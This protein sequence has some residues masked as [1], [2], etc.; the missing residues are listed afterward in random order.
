M[1]SLLP[2]IGREAADDLSKLGNKLFER[3]KLQTATPHQ[4]KPGDV[5]HVFDPTEESKSFAEAFLK[6]RVCGEPWGKTGCLH[7]PQL[8]D[9]RAIARKYGFRVFAPRKEPTLLFQQADNEE[10]AVQQVAAAYIIIL[11]PVEL[12]EWTIKLRC[13][14]EH[15]AVTSHE[16]IMI[17]S[18]VGYTVPPDVRYFIFILPIHLAD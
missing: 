15:E 14:E 12:K 9:I 4:A 1:Y 13:K 8:E 3:S 16:P 6:A 18:K 5:R 11:Q 2:S 10:A 17:L 7:V